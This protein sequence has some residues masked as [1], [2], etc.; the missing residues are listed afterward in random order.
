MMLPEKIEG[1]GFVNRNALVVRVYVFCFR[2]YVA[3]PLMKS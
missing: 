1:I 2:N 3:L